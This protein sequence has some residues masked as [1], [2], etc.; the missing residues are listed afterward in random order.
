MVFVP[1]VFICTRVE[2]LYHVHAISHAPFI[3]F[4]CSI[5][6]L[7]LSPEAAFGIL[8]RIMNQSCVTLV[9]DSESSVSCIE[10]LCVY[11]LKDTSFE[12]KGA[13]P[14]AAGIKWLQKLP[15]MQIVLGCGAPISYPNGEKGTSTW[16][17]AA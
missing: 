6:L 2:G 1:R 15:L 14:P 17:S 13:Q 3:C 8:H 10:L 16:C 12:R 7:A 5:V 11:I 9:S 4:L